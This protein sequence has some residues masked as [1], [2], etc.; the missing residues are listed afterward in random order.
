MNTKQAHHTWNADYYYN[1]HTEGGR[2]ASTCIKCGKCEQ[3][4]PQHLP[5]RQLLEDVVKE[6][7]KPAEAK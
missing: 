7:E 3:V 6:F 5:I 4:C 1:L 2:K